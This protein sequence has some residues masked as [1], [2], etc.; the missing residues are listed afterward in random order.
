MDERARERRRRARPDP[1]RRSADN[2][3][4]LIIGLPGAGKTILAQQFVFPSATGAPR[5]LLLHG[6]RAVRKDAPLRPDAQL[7]RR[8]AVGRTVFYE[9]LGAAAGDGG[10]AAIIERIRADQGAAPGDHRDRQLQGAGRVRGRRPRLPAVPARPRRTADGLPRHRFWVGEY[11]ADEIAHGAGVRG[12]RRDHLAATE[13]VNERTLRLIQVTKLRGS[14]FRSGRHT[15]RLSEDG[16]T[17]S[18]A[19]PIPAAGY[20]RRRRAVSSGIAA[21]DTMPDRATAGQ[22]DA[23]GR[24]VRRRQDADGA[25]LHLQRCGER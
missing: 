11:S 13:R 8:A 1:R 10:L 24:A 4:N 22:L 19:W 2:G 17:S 16:I 18:P 21:L 7:L 3:I 14:A 9:D 15:Y 12:R 25:A 20:Y 5:D 23:G 6:L